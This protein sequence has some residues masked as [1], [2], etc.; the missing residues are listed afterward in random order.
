MIITFKKPQDISSEEKLLMYGLF[1][2]CHAIDYEAYEAN[3]D[4]YSEYALGYEGERLV[5]LS[6]I[7][8]KLI[9]LTSSK[10]VSLYVGSS[11]VDPDF[12]S[13]GFIPKVMTRAIIS[14]MFKYPFYKRYIWCLAATY[15]PY[16]FYAKIVKKGYPRRNQNY[17]DKI[18]EIRDNLIK[19]CPVNFGQNGWSNANPVVWTLKDDA[20]KITSGDLNDPDVAFYNSFNL[21]DHYGLFS[22]APAS[23]ENILFYVKNSTLKNARNLMRRIPFVYNRG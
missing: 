14:T 20:S 3:F 7:E 10:I 5:A 18:L 11:C 1:S 6:A 2:S 23:V 22:F 4:L 12:R 19:N 9:T 15:K 8:T 13:N 16:M 21:P 17:S